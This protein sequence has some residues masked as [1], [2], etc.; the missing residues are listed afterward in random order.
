[1]D[2]HPGCDFSD[3]E[4]LADFGERQ[5]FEVMKV[6]RVAVLERKREYSAQQLAVFGALNDLVDRVDQRWIPENELRFD[7]APSVVV[8]S[9]G[10]DGP[11]QPAPGFAFGRRRFGRCPPSAERFLPPLF[12]G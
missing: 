8:A 7:Q 11:V 4:H 6:D 2:T 10:G 9:Q 5:A 3:P 1:M 12:T